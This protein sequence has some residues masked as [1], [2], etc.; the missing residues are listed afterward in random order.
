[1]AE[2]RRLREV[3]RGST[4]NL[5]RITKRRKADKDVHK[6]NDG[7]KEDETKEDWVVGR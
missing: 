5:S 1:M 6:R 7:G 4:S 3:R 2:P